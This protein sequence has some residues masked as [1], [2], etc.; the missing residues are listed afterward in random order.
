MLFRSVSCSH[1]LYSWIYDAD[2]NLIFSDA[3]SDSYLNEILFHNI[4]KEAIIDYGMTYR[5]PLVLSSTFDLLWIAVFE[6]RENELI[7]IHLLGPAFTLD[8]SPKSIDLMLQ[9]LTIS[10]VWKRSLAKLLLTLP[11]VSF[12][13]C[14]QYALM[15][16]LVVTDDKLTISDIRYPTPNMHIN[17]A[18]T[19]EVPL[20][21]DRSA[22][23][24]AE[25]LLLNMVR[26]GNLNYQ[27]NLTKAATVSSGVG[28]QLNKPI[29]QAQDSSIIF[30][31]L[32][33]R[34]AIEGGLSP[35]SAYTLGDF[36]IQNAENC[37]SMSEII[38]ENHTMYEDF[39]NRVHKLKN[40]PTISKPI[41]S[42]CDYI[43]MHIQD[44]LS[45]QELALR[46][47]Y[48]EYY[49]TRK[50]KKEVGSSINDYIKTSK[51]KYAKILLASTQLSIQDISDELHFCSRSY[52]ADTFRKMVGISPTDYRTE[53]QKI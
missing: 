15:L 6:K 39:I 34:A 26:E 16:H 41:Q 17:S 29:R 53:N 49:L 2:F 11:I 37:T 25:Q 20:T 47:G 48:T 8:V 22:T 24:M 51:I 10:L 3:P 1:H 28:I 30:T 40:S 46:V 14:I 7:A 36:Y 42:C 23:W 19:T 12:S 52:F 43:D 45:I 27:A 32:C 5:E 21:K 38:S 44:K 4:S 50:F 33:T 18:T 13:N 31:S 35:E 9:P